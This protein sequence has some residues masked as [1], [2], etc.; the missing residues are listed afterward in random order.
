MSALIALLIIAAAIWFGLPLVGVRPRMGRE[1]LDSI[2]DFSRAMTALDPRAPTP[3]ATRPAPRAP[4]PVP[5]AAAG[6][7]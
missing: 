6:R 7:R 1:H 4:R 2:S 3:R 5:R